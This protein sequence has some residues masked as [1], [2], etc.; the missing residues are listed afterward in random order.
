MLGVRFTYLVPT[1]REPIRLPF[2]FPN[3]GYIMSC[4]CKECKQV[5]KDFYSLSQQAGRLLEALVDE[6]LLEQLA[7]LSAEEEVSIEEKEL[8][9][10]CGRKENYYNGYDKLHALKHRV[11]Q[12]L[13]V[14]E[15]YKDRRI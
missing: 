4:I 5:N 15:G 6:R 9:L 3:K 7:I 14:V 10:V 1:K 13:G 8:M 11:D 12:L 2:S